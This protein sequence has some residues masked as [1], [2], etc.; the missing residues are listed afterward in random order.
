VYLR[1]SEAAGERYFHMPDPDGL[2]LY[3]DLK[4]IAFADEGRMPVSVEMQ[5]T[6][7][8]N[9]QAEVRVV[10]EHVLAD[11]P[12][13][14]QVSIMGSQANDRWELKITGPN[15]FE[16]SYTL[17]GS[18]GEHRPEVIRVILAKMLPGRML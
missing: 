10:I 1:L 15:G 7:D 5:Y 9:M 3:N 13:D 12:G 4:S 17:E 6:G 8:P 18:G 2:V 11:R 16:R 14:W